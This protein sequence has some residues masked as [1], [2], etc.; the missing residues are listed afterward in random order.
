MS[1][2]SS[3][4]DGALSSV[5]ILDLTDER[6]IYGAKLLADLGAD[7][8]RLEP[9]E[10]DPLRHRGPYKDDVPGPT[11]SLYHAFF[12][13]NRRFATVDRRSD[14]GG[15]QLNRLVRWADVV[16]DN[17]SIDPVAVQDYLDKHPQLVIVESSSFGP[18]GPW[19]DYL[20][21]DLV[22][23][24]LGGI[25]AT[26]GDV[27]TVPLKGFGEIA[28][29]VS[30]AYTAIAALTGLHHARATG[31]NQGQG[32]RIDVP[33]H[34]CLASCL[35]HVLMWY[36]YQETLA[37]ASGPH[38]P[39]R[40]GLHWSNAYVVMPAKDGSIMITPTPDME[41]QLMWLVEEDVHE[42]L[43]DPKYLEPENLIL[44]IGRMMELLYKWVATKEVEPFFYQAQERHSPYGWVLPIE[45][46]GS[47]P[48]LAARNWWADYTLGDQAAKGPGAPYQFAETPWRMTPYHGPG[49]DTAAVLAEIG[50][51]D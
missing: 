48:Q 27:D 44:L 9:P 33:V 20:A 45:K 25:C 3:P 16:I 15:R 19:R 47:N 11:N 22:A 35:E 50:W 34:E 23:S 12:A 14:D 6:A 7:V 36:W 38:L 41:A 1:D 4:A 37:F 24:A 18:D 42:D 51:E 26:T 10:G 2:D 32:Q 40:G 17:G 5:K 28:F 30:G 39:R 8:I 46:V 29:Y 49:H 13:S 21:P 31:P 43:L